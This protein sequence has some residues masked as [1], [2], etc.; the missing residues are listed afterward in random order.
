MLDRHRRHATGGQTRPLHAMGAIIA[1]AL[2]LAMCGGAAAAAPSHVVPPNG[3]LAGRGYSYYLERAW[4]VFFGA[5]G[6]C[7]TA[8]VGGVRVAVVN[9]SD[10][11]SCNE[12]AGRPVY[13]SGPSAECSTLPGDHNGFGKSASQL[14]RCAR[15]ELKNSVVH[16]WLDGHQVPNFASFITTTNA[17]AFRL[18][19]N[20]FPG[21]K[22]RKGRS[23]AYGY[24][25]LLTGLTKGNHTVRHAGT[26]IGTKIDTTATLRVR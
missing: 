6:P 18:P 7:Q 22:Q 23:A 11:P 10:G 21:V 24:G 8:T 12:P 25:L 20:R 1:T 16:A 15:A 5:P 26:V 2:V 17:F 14:R 4:K 3:K 19:K 13:V 9:P